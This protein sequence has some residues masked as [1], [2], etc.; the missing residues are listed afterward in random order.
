MEIDSLSSYVNEVSTLRKKYIH[1][2]M[3]TFGELLFRG[4]DNV[5]H[6]LLPSLARE[7]TTPCDI[8][9]FNEERN[10]IELAKCKY[11][12]IFRDEMKPVELLALLRHYGIPTR[13]LDVTEN[14]LVALYFACSG[15]SDVD[16]EVFVFFNTNSHVD[17]APEINAIADTYKLTRGAIYL[18]EHFFKAAINQPY[19]NERRHVYDISGDKID[20]AERIEEC[21]A[22]PLFVHAPVHTLR[23]QLQQGRFILFP[24]RIGDGQ[25]GKVFEPIIDPIPKNHDCIKQRFSIKKEN[26]KDILEDLKLCGICE[27]TLFF[28]SVDKVCNGVVDRVKRMCYNIH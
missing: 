16:G 28:D 19:F 3:P 20:P 24:N 6:T 25:G 4:H 5:Q 8:T 13:L 15:Q 2:E 21:C 22:N 27:A 14:A 17:N 1:S 12:D 10:L 9:I 18:L 26:K 11:P 23:Q 7:R